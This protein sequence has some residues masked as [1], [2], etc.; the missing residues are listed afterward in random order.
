MARVSDTSVVIL[1]Y[2]VSLI[3]G[4]LFVHTT[5]RLVVSVLAR[6]APARYSDHCDA[7]TL[8]L[9]VT[10]LPNSLLYSSLRS[11]GM[12]GIRH[13]LLHLNV[14]HPFNVLVTRD[15]ALPVKKPVGAASE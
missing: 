9:L 11:F 8:C 3:S 13:Y 15:V 6:P 2:V 14:V 7:T 12:V 5:V 10:H 1:L 4:I